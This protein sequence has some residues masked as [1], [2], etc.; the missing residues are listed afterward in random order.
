MENLKK[1]LAL[2]LKAKSIRIQ[3]PIP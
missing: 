2:A 1:D 3:A